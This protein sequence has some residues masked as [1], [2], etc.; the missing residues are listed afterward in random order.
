MRVTLAAALALMLISGSMAQGTSPM[1]LRKLPIS[2]PAMI[3]SFGPEKVQFG[4]LRVPAGKGPFPVAIIY[5]GGCLLRQ[6]DDTRGTAAMAT[7]LTARGIATWNVDY[8]A[9]GDAG[10]GYPGSYHDWGDAAD[11]LRV[12]AKSH[13][14]DLNRVIAVGHS[15]GAPA[16]IF[17][18]SRA[19]LPK[20]SSIRRADPLPIRAV[21]AVDGPPDPANLVGLDEQVC[22]RPVVKE[23]LG[24]T[25]A[26]QP[27]RYKEVSPVQHLPLGVPVHL[28]SSSFVLPPPLAES[29]QAAAVAKGDKVEIT[30]IQGG[31]FNVIAP[32]QPQWAKVEAIIL[33][34]V[35][36]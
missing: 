33:A 3:S 1:D 18:A 9:L 27:A 4:E 16:A 19:K 31:H 6:V 20:S 34:A 35:P 23:F 26:E 21:V 14:L 32:G 15:A 8:R 2:K 7:A 22:G 25:S 24:G 30:Q 13:P 29:Y 36:K 11:H 28:I 12:L 5:H 17:A 10:A